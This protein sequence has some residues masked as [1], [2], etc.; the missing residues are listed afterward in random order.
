MR[1]WSLSPVYLDAAGLVAGWRE[2]LLA[3]K[4]LDGGTKG[5]TRH[6]QL[7]R[8][9]EQ[10]DPVGA[11]GAYLSGLHEESLARGY[12]FDASRIL[13]PAEGPLTETAWAGSIPVTQGQLDLEWTHLMA[14]LAARSPDVAERFAHE[15]AP[16]PHSI[17]AVVPGPVASWERAVL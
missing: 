7:E 4:V 5:Y 11:I 3:Q 2:T 10:A 1:L 6:P 12:R 8:W 16:A 14:K 15:D 17:F 13:R 9:R